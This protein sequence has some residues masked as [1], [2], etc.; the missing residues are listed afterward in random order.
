LRECLLT[1]T[2]DDVIE[3]VADWRDHGLQYAVI[4][5]VSGVQPSLR[6]GLAATL[7]LTRILR[8]LRKL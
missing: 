5:N 7:P 6:H 8:G 3:Q 2:S 1:G 4:F